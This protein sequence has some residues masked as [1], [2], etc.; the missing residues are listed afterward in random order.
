MNS[1]YPRK[2][3]LSEKKQPSILWSS[4]ITAVAGYLLMALLNE[5]MGAK[6]WFRGDIWPY[7]QFFGG[8]LAAVF[9]FWAI[10]MTWKGKSWSTQKKVSFVVVSALLQVAISFI[11]S[12][13]SFGFLPFPVAIYAIGLSLA[14]N[15]LMY[16]LF[17]TVIWVPAMLFEKRKRP[18]STGEST[19]SE[20][21][22][23]SS[24]E[25]RRIELP[26]Q[27]AEQEIATRVTGGGH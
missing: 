17:G 22:S 19:D 25:H 1:N 21:V 2:E 4:A 27:T 18:K 6:D 26:T 11:Q 13:F 20:A 5:R 8:I 16:A 10:L 24:L 23:S 12:Q 15:S 14:R 7:A 9:T 3:S